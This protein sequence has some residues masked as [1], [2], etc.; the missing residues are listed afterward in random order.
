V[1]HSEGLVTFES[2]TKKYQL[3]AGVL[4]LANDFTS[5]NSLVQVIRPYLED[6]S[7]LHHCT[8]VA[9]EPSGQEH[10]IV[11]A[12]SSVNTGVSVSV[13]VGT[14]VPFMISATGRCFAA[15]SQW[16]VAELKRKFSQL[17][18]HNPPSFKTWYNDV[19]L[20]RQTGYG[21]DAGNY[22]GGITIV[23]APILSS[24]NVMSGAIVSVCVT[25]QLSDAGLAMLAKDLQR[26]A[27][28]VASQLG[29]GLTVDEPAR[30]HPALPGARKRKTARP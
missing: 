24:G 25:D 19:Q 3:G 6:I 21:V 16:P 22:I 2:N 1:L 13:T 14:R 8:T 9:V 17:R 4:A 30:G 20:I 12:T 7:R 5:K 29:V 18:W 10:Y 11:V 28:R 27:A 26:A 23:A 15:Y